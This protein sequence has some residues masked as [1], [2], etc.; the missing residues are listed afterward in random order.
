[1][2]GVQSCALPIWWTKDPAAYEAAQ[3]TF[4]TAFHSVETM[5]ATN[6][7]ID[8]LH[9]VVVSKWVRAHGGGEIMM[10]SRPNGIDH[11]TLAHE[12]GHY[13]EERDPRI[14][15]LATAFLEKRTAGETATKL[16][17]LTKNTGYEDHEISKPDKFLNP[18]SGKI[19]AGGYAT[20]ITSM[21][22]QYAYGYDTEGMIKGLFGDPD[23]FAYTYAIMHLG[24]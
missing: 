22:F 13:L 17:E 5:V 18:Y 19:Y 9:A 10:Q 3:K 14:A 2:T 16:S 11:T 24:E 1:V 15:K 20:E 21:G 23:Y 7:H 12:F 8:L 4:N 6:P